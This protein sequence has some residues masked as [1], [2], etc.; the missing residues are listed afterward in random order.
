M[1]HRR[2]WFSLFV[3]CCVATSATANAETFALKNGKQLE[4]SVVRAVGNT[5][6]IRLNDRGMYQC[7]LNELDWVALTDRQ[8][9]VIQGKLLNWSEGTYFIDTYQG[10]TIAIKDGHIIKDAAQPRPSVDSPK[11]QPIM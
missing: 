11:H 8:G 4:G 9:Q 10:G 5:I 1:R 2:I 6:S 7:P 3:T